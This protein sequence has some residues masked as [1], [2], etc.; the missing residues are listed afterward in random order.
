MLELLLILA[1]LLSVAASAQ[2]QPISHAEA[3]CSLN[4]RSRGGST[5]ITIRSVHTAG[6]NSNA[7]SAQ[8]KASPTLSLSAIH[9]SA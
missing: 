3:V 7:E 5:L 2:A 8:G 4:C 9:R 6:A 1:L